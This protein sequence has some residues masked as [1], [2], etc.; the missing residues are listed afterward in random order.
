MGSETFFITQSGVLRALCFGFLLLTGHVARAQSVDSIDYVFNFDDHTIHVKNIRLQPD[1]DQFQNFIL[2]S[3]WN[4]GFFEA[5]LDSVVHNNHQIELWYS[6]SIRYRWAETPILWNQDA[7][8]VNVPDCASI[9]KGEYFEFTKLTDCLNIVSSEISNQGYLSHQVKVDSLDIDFNKKH[10]RARL[11]ADIGSP[12]LIDTI[13]FEGL[14]KIDAEW[15]KRVIG[16]NSGQHLTQNLI[17]KT[18]YRINKLQFFEPADAPT[19]YNNNG[20]YIVSYN[21]LE[22]PLTHFDLIAGYAPGSNGSSMIVG[23]GA[24][25]IRNVGFNGLDLMMQFDRLDVRVGKLKIGVDQNYILGYPLG[26]TSSFSLNQQD[27]LWQSRDLSIGA[28]VE[29]SDD[30][31]ILFRYTNQVSVSGNATESVLNDQTG[32]FGSVEFL[33][34]N[35]KSGYETEPGWMLHVNAETGNQLLDNVNGGS[36]NK[37]VRQRLSLDLERH[38]RI[39]KR[40]NLVAGLHVGYLSKENPQIIDYWRLGGAQSIRGYREDQFF[41][42]DYIWSDIE[43]RYFLEKNSYLF[44]FGQLGR[45]EL[46]K[47]TDIYTDKTY[48]TQSFGLGL[49]YSTNLGLIKFT[50][51]KSP[52][53]PFTNAKVHV[54]IQADF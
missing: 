15:L 17:Q 2:Q 42:D 32:R 1:T 29:L 36:R 41:T 10:V 11:F 18:V 38:H 35:R 25:N 26:L 19:M 48:Y 22:K 47:R 24:L 21:L 6:T 34:N 49:A 51:A 43:Y 50:Y 30:F 27:T 20:R 4:V 8:K 13:E 53:D 12:S 52:E 23:N 40:H 39:W 54:G 31:R 16:I 45:L 44:V 14:S 7:Q 28:W 5:D 37:I 9:K 46:G 3:A 33:F